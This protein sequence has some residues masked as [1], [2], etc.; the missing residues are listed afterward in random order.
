VTRVY[1]TYRI[2]SKITSLSL[3]IAR[4]SKGILKRRVVDAYR[5]RGFAVLSTLKK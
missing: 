3:P 2:I 4:V 5:M 1:Y